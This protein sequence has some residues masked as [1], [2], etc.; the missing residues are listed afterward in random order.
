MKTHEE[1]TKPYEEHKPYEERTK[2]Y[3][4]RMKIYARVYQELLD[5]V[6]KDT[7]TGEKKTEKKINNK[8]EKSLSEY[9]KFVKQESKKKEYEGIKGKDLLVKIAKR[10]KLEKNRK[11]LV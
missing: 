4:E 1:R 5:L 11:N 8:T 6:N 3:E 2:P 10:W 7:K 9:Q